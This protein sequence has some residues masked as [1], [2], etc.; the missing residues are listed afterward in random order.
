MFLYKSLSFDDDIKIVIEV[1]VYENYEN[2]K[3]FINNHTSN[4][5]I[6]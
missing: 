4:K 5:I 2:I 1:R 3:K 6:N